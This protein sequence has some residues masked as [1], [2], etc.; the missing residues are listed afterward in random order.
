VSIDNESEL[1]GMRRVGRLVAETLRV[2]KTAVR[3]GMTTAE[4]DAE[5]ERFLRSRGARSAPQLTYAFPGFTCISVNDEIVHGVPGARALAPG[6]LVSIDVTA[7]LDGFIADAAVTVGLPPVGDTARRLVRAARA[8][9][10]RAMRVATAGVPVAEIG[11]AIE[12][13]VARRG[14][15]VVR[16]LSG[17]GVGRRIHEPPDVPNFY[18]TRTRGT[19][20][21]GLVLA[22]EPIIAAAPSRLV[23]ARDGWTLRT[24]TRVLA[25]HHEH[26][27]MITSGRPEILTAA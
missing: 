24:A 12:G 5:G 26:T 2:M 6:D 18:D 10:V 19:L 21:D 23:E 17:H 3:P 20:T 8:A 14:F 16:E 1:A 25:A 7:E 11:R 22:V 27:V 4:L 9:F 15:A 13:E